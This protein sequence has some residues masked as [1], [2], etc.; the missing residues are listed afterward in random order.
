MRICDLLHWGH[1][2]LFLKSSSAR[3]DAELL[4][5]HALKKPVT[6]LLAHDE[7]AVGLIRTW[8]Y[9]SLIARRRAGEPLAYITGHREFYFL[10]FEVNRHTLVPRPDTEI[11][12][13]AVIHYLANPKSKFRNPQLLMDV[14]TGSGCIAV[15]ILKNVP[16]LRAVATDLSR[17]ALRTA[18]RNAKKHGVSGRIR[19]LHSDLL[20]SVPPALF[21]E[22]ELIVCANLPYIPTDFPVNPE[23][24][25]EPSVALYGGRDGLA[26]YK[27]LIDELAAFSPR[28]IFLEC[29]EF[30]LAILGVRLPGY[31]LVRTEKMTGLAR[32]AFLE[33][34]G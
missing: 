1:E 20:A 14:G 17:S 24:R 6:F 7:T 9:R 29:F 34:Q 2:Q 30:Q 13:E 5:A 10:D 8:R 21:G 18:H 32:L 22:K 33:R 15:S 16:G 19:F 27:R 4:L 12:T 26:V 31:R 25:F 3:L 23:T 28:A 11:L